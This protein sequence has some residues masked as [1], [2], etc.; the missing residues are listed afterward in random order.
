MAFMLGS[1]VRQRRLACLLCISP[2]FLQH[3][4]I[5]PSLRAAAIPDSQVLLFV[6]K[7]RHVKS[8]NAVTLFGL[9]SV[10][11]CTRNSTDAHA[12]QQECQLFLCTPVFFLRAHLHIA[13]P[14]AH[15]PSLGPPLQAVPNY[16]IDGTAFLEDDLLVVNIHGHHTLCDILG[17]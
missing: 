16:N 2:G 13:T 11:R 17:F 3:T 1:Q 10:R 8:Y 4:R 6:W 12:R 15:L 14:S 7:K 9:W 5:R